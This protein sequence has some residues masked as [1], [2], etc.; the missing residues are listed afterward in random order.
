MIAP[1]FAPENTAS[2]F[3]GTISVVRLSPAF[4]FRLNRAHSIL[5]SLF[6]P[7]LDILPPPQRH[8][9][10][11]LSALPDN[12]VLYGGTAIALHIGHRQSVDFDFFIDAPLDPSGLLPSLPLLSGAIVMQR[13]PSTISCTVDRGGVIKLS[14][15]GV[16]N[17]PRLLP[18]LIARDNGLR[19]ASLL[20]LA[21][22]T[23]T[24]VQLRAEAKDYLDIDALIEQGG[25]TLPMALAV[26]SAQ[27]GDAF[28]PQNALKALCYFDDGN[29][30]QLPGAVKDRLVKAAT[31][32]DLDRLPAL[33]PL[34]GAPGPAPEPPP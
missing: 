3:C 19:V 17:L 22:T 8:L 11:E 30:G 15:F 26:A 7:R 28:N 1:C 33:V 4:R 31:A 32:V 29:L 21:G 5:S 13:E 25:I 6:H 10:G 24:V 16:P 18:P 14:F 34:N 2:L 23:V 9:W 12:F 27:Y 20:D